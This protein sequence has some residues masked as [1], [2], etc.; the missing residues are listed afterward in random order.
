MLSIEQREKRRM[1][2]RVFT[3]ATLTTVAT[4]IALV[5]LGCVPP[6]T[7]TSGQV[8]SPPA[9]PKA[10]PPQSSRFDSGYAGPVIPMPAPERHFGVDAQSQQEMLLRE[11]RLS[12][13]PLPSSELSQLKYDV[14]ILRIQVRELQ[15]AVF[16][17][18]IGSGPEDGPLWPTVGA[19]TKSILSPPV[20][21]LSVGDDN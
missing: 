7:P 8:I 18:R 10:S 3:Y 16:R 1:V 13:S 9:V 12:P 4:G 14:R 17:A 15:Q 21:P 11:Q 5:M 2:S 20:S 19:A 6:M